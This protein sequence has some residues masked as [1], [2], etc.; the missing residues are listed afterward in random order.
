MKS[1]GEI[2]SQRKYAIEKTGVIPC[3]NCGSYMRKFSLKLIPTNRPDLPHFPKFIPQVRESC[4][5][6]LKFIKFSTQSSQLVEMLNKK[7]EGIVF[8]SEGNKCG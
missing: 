8:T 7:L 5:D 4:F 2:L 3:L 1:V 6:C